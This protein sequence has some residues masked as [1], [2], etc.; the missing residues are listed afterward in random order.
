MG[1]KSIRSKQTDRLLAV[2]LKDPLAWQ[3]GYALMKQTGLQSG[4]LYPVLL[5][6][7]EQG[8]LESEWRDADET[9][10]RPRHVYRLTSVGLA[11]VREQ[12]VP[13]GRKSLGLLGAKA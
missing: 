4:T 12:I 11:F 2:M 5:R 9:G 6:L 10:K 8:L 1:R 13:A 3:Y 7:C